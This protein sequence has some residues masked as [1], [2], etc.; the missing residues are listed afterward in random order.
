MN[1]RREACRISD[2]LA[3]S[4][5]VLYA[6]SDG[7]PPDLKIGRPLYHRFCGGFSISKMINGGRAEEELQPSRRRR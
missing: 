6:W 2:P 3:V 5:V 1:D 7:L 4:D